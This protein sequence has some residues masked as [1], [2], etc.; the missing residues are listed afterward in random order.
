MEWTKFANEIS[1]L[2]G[3]KGNPIAITYSMTP[4]S[5]PDGRKHRV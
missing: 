5:T 4:P 3:I 2:L 1:E